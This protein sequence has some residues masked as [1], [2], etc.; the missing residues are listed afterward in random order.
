MYPLDTSES[1][2]GVK[3]RGPGPGDGGGSYIRDYMAGASLFEM[4]RVQ[5][6]PETSVSSEYCEIKETITLS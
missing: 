6:R 3:D 4:R 5:P 2:A 1:D